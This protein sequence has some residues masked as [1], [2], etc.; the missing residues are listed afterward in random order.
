MTDEEHWDEV[1]RLWRAIRRDFHSAVEE[2]G[3]LSDRHDR[4]LRRLMR[5]WDTLCVLDIGVAA[6]LWHGFS[7]IAGVMGKHGDPTGPWAH[8]H[9]GFQEILGVI[10]VGRDAN[11]DTPVE[12]V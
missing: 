2:V 10:T 4:A 6:H 11:P 1:E 9:R 8:R 12:T 3:G 5:N 7:E